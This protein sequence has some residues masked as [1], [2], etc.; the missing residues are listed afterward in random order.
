MPE[1]TS[2]RY[3]RIVEKIEKLPSLPQIVI[4]LIKVVNSAYSSADDVARLIDKDPALTGS[5]LRLANSAFYGMP[6]SI[7][8]VSSAVVVLGFNTIR[9]IVLS[10]AVMKI[11]RPAAMNGYFD[12]QLFWNHSVTCAAGAKVLSQNCTDSITH[13]PESAFCAGILHDIGKLIFAQYVPKDFAYACTY[14]VENEVPLHR[15]EQ[16]FLGI[17]HCHMGHI[18]ADKWGLPSNLE[19]AIVYHHS[20]PQSANRFLDLVTIVH[21]ADQMAHSAGASLW[22]T[23]QIEK[24]W[25]QAFAVLECDEIVYAS[26]IAAV[27]N[28]IPSV[29]EFLKTINEE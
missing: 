12:P 23:E 4:K 28:I 13:D 9:S 22:E 19:C 3:S 17:T 11:F 16:K 26:C 18:L 1:R 8:S 21:C 27:K 29:Q 14:A 20:P 10:A 5:V 7:S 6:R 25:E 15:A 24:R 2:E